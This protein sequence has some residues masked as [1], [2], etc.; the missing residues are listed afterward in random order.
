MK[1]INW[2]A[3]APTTDGI[4]WFDSGLLLTTEPM[5][6]QVLD[7]HYINK[8]NKMKISEKIKIITRLAESILCG[9]EEHEAD[10]PAVVI[11]SDTN[12]MWQVYITR[13]TQ[14]AL[15]YDDFESP[16]EIVKAR[17]SNPHEMEA[18]Y[19]VINETLV[20][21]LDEL[22]ELLLDSDVVIPRATPKYPLGSLS[23][24]EKNVR[25]SFSR[26]PYLE[27]M[28]PAPMPVDDILDV[29]ED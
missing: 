8:G 25:T 26:T 13:P 23:I 18:H 16:P 19:F 2:I 10:A 1:K 20:G 15:D 22:Y 6:V 17:T 14:E 21:A 4:Y 24:T 29:L 5:V 11:Y 9:S 28:Y 27:D 12:D 7:G 3:G